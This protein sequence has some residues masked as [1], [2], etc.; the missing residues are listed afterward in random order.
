MKKLKRVEVDW[1]DA[2]S[3]SGWHGEDEAKEILPA[4]THTV[5]YLL[6]QNRQYVRITSGYS[7]AEGM[8]DG[9]HVIPKGW[10]TKITEL[11]QGA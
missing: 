5:G 9:I 11:K 10:V 2:H 8:Y 6:K 1:I 3:W 4:C 7:D